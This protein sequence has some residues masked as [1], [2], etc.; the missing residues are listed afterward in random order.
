MTFD[1]RNESAGILGKFTE[2]PD[3]T[4]LFS[5]E[6]VD[7]VK[8]HIKAHFYENPNTT[9]YLVDEMNRVHGIFRHKGEDNARG[10]L[11]EQIGLFYGLCYVVS[12][13]AVFVAGIGSA[14]IAHSVLKLIIVAAAMTLLY[15]GIVKAKIQNCIEG[16]VAVTILS[17]LAWLITRKLI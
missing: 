17:V 12:L 13:N 11:S 4:D 10:Q 8:L 2:I 16:A 5:S 3:E 9:V 14:R 7:E 6:S 15:V 1:E